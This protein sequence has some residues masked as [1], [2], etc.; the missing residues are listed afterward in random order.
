MR[1]LEEA[2]DTY[3]A[4]LHAY[5]LMTNHV[6]LLLT[7]TEKGQVSRFM[8][9]W[10]RRYAFYFNRSRHRSGAVF[11]RRFWSDTIKSDYYF[12]ACMRYIESNP[13]RAGMR[14]HAAEYPWSSH[15]Q[16]AR[17]DP[18]RP[19]T[20]HPV[21][22]AMG[23]SVAVRG[24]AYQKFFEVPQ[25][26]IEIEVLRAGVRPRSRGRQPGTFQKNNLVHSL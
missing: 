10:S 16:N 6:H 2:L 19:L 5:V 8:H 26:S 25:P 17:G 22:L 11:E 9:G 1:Y 24:N 18:R 15:Q 21:Y 7:G 13:V 23:R 3:G 20:P 4:V 14:S 12:L